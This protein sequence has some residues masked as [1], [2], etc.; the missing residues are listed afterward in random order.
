MIMYDKF[1][2]LFKWLSHDFKNDKVLFISES[3]NFIGNVLASLI[4]A[5]SVPKPNWYIVYTSYT[6]ASIGGIIGAIKRKS[7]Q[8]L[9]MNI[10]FLLIDGYAILKLL[11]INILNSNFN[12]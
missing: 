2:K 10:L 11:V 7:F 1:K 5:I 8:L 6:L 12:L 4:V 3:T 9:N